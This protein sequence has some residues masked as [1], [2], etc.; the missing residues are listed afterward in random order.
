[1]SPISGVV[2]FI[3]AHTIGNLPRSAQLS[4][5]AQ[6]LLK[7][8]DL[9]V[10]L[11]NGVLLGVDRFFQLGHVKIILFP[12]ILH[13]LDDLCDLSILILS[14][15]LLLLKKLEL[16][17]VMFEQYFLRVIMLVFKI[18]GVHSCLLPNE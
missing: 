17:V 12:F 9:T 2:E 13:I 15:S 3:V 1:M 18:L 8:E 14:Q 5:F 11:I 6:H 16:L 4:R 10:L 7:C